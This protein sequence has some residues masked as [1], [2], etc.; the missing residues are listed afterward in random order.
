[1]GVQLVLEVWVLAGQLRELVEI[2]GFALELPERG[3]PAAGAR[4][5]G[6]DPGGALLVLPEPRLAQLLLERADALVQ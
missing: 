3:Q 6:A 1:M 4:M 5:L 2:A